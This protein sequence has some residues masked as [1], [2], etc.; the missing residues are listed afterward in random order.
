MDEQIQSGETGKAKN[1]ELIIEAK[2]FFEFHKKE[3]GESIRKGKNVI[4][5][6]FVKLTEFSNKLA[7]ESIT[8]PEETI[9]IVELALEETGLVSGVF[10]R[11]VNFPKSQEIKIRSIRSKHLNEMLLRELSARQVM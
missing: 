11:F 4:H 8:N 7:E 6:D 3:I 1:E 5:L 2:N 9:R 10:V